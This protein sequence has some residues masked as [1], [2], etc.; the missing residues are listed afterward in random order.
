[1]FDIKSYGDNAYLAL[2][3]L[4]S[5]GLLLSGRVS[6]LRVFGLLHLILEKRYIF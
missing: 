2:L 4:I 3:S 1:M 5:Q 6:L